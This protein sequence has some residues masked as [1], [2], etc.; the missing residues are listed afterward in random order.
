M[1]TRPATRAEITYAA[2]GTTLTCACTAPDCT[3][4]TRVDAPDAKCSD[5]RWGYHLAAL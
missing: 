3:C 4:L 2:H 1:A 5:C